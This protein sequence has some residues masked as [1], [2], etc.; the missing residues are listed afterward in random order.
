M[1]SC[2]YYQILGID[3]RA[4]PAEIKRAYRRLA[5]LFHPDSQ[6][7]MANHERIAQ[8]NAAYEVLKDPQQRSRYDQAQ[9]VSSV[10]GAGGAGWAEG[11]ALDPQSGHGRGHHNPT[12]TARN[13]EIQLQKW[14]Q[15]V[16]NPVQLHLAHIINQLPA[17]IRYLSADP[18][19]DDLMAD[20]QDYLAECRGQLEE[21]QISF[22]SMPNPAAIASVAAHLCYCINHIEDALED[23]ERFTSCYDDHY[24]TTGRELFRICQKL[25]QEAHYALEAVL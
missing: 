8:V 12:E 22:Q 13:T 20:F 6:H 15:Q 24:L 9:S 18:Y 21:A 7:Q 17:E 23:L 14:L 10:I 2:N 4:T 25:T 3:S 1:A 5:K 19:D 16:Y 11:D